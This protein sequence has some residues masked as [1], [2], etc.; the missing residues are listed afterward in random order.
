MKIYRLLLLAFTAGL[1]A[2]SF[3][4]VYSALGNPLPPDIGDAVETDGY[5][6]SVQFTGCAPVFLQTV[7]PAFEQ[8]VVELVNQERN[9]RGLPPLKRVEALDQAAR[10]HGMDMA[11]DNYFKHDSYD[12]VGGQLVKAC[13]WFTRVGGFYSGWSWLG[14][15]IAAGYSTPEEVMNGWMN[16][17][18]HRANILSASPR[19]IGVG[20]YGGGYYGHY[21]VQ[22][23]GS[24]S[25]NYPLIIDQEKAAIDS[26]QVNLYI[27]G[28]GVWQE[29]RLKNDDQAWGAWQPFTKQVQWTLPWTQG[30]HTVSVE[31][32]KSGQSTAG[33]FAS[34]T[35]ELTTSGIQLGNLPDQIT[36][37]YNL[38][39]RELYPGPVTLQP[40]NTLSSLPLNWQVSSSANWIKVSNTSGTSPS[41]TTMIQPGDDVIQKAGQL[42]GSLVVMATGGVSVLGSP[43]EISVQVYVVNSMDHQLYLPAVR[44]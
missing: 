16:S 19:E 41:G 14:E 7:N 21:W 25:S 5:S 42:S 27:Y 24:R 33:A 32:R 20:Y 26:P 28:E 8:R 35:I 13:D 1:L 2:A 22:D 38:E 3:F 15:N 17:D 37:I 11:V 29:M 6:P 40:L 44:R 31:L 39:K 4:P 10:Y 18:G 43:K 30:A 9:A 36:F 23:F 34:D 12:L